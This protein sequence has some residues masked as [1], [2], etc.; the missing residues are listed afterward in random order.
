[1]KTTM[2]ITLLM[3]TIASS[4]MAQGPSDPL[5]SKQ[6]ALENNGQVV[7]KY[8]SDLERTSIKGSSGVDI[9]WVDT[10]DLPSSQKDLV[11]AVID[12]GVDITHPDLQGRIWFNEAQCANATNQATL[13][14]NGYNYLETSTIVKDDIGHGTHVAGII[15]AN[16]N[17]NI[18]VSGAAD[19][20]VKIMP[21]KVLNSEVNG[22]VYKNKVITDV[23][24]DA[25]TFAVKNGAQVVNLSLGWPKLIDLAKVKKAFEY[26]EEN[27][28]TIIA[29]AGNNNKDLPVF[30]CAYE[31]VICVGALGNNGELTSFTNHGS[32]VDIVA[33]GDA[34]VSTLPLA[35]ESRG[36]RI[37]GY[38]TKNGSSQAAPYVTA[39][40]A[41]LKLLHPGLT[42]DQ[43]RS[44]LFRSSKKLSSERSQRFVKFGALDMKELLRLADEKTEKAFVNPQI[45]SLTEVK[46]NSTDR[47][48]SFNLDL[49]NMSG[50]P[51]KGLVCLK[52][53]SE[54]IELDQNCLKVES[55]LAHKTQTIP[56]TGAVL[57]MGSDSH[58][59]IQIQIDENVYQT[60]LVLSRDLNADSEVISHSLG[61]ASFEDMGAINGDKRISRM[62]RVF[63][64]HKRIGFPEY[65]YLERLKQTELETKI[66]LLTKDD[67]KFLIKNITLPKVE[68]VIS[69]HRQD[70]NQDGKMDYFVYT[71]SKKKD[72]LQFYI[73]DEKLNPLFKNYPLWTMTLSTFEGLPVDAVQEKF[74]W[75][76][77]KHPLLGNVLVP[78]IYRAYTMPEVDNSKTIADRV[79]GAMS[80]QYYLNPVVTG[81]KMMLELRVIDSVKMMKVL[82]KEFGVTTTADTKSVI[83]LKPFPQTAEESQKGKIRSL[84]VVVEDGVSKLYQVSLSVNGN[85][86]SD[87]TQ[88]DSEKGIEQSLIYPI[89]DTKTGGITK[90]SVF[91]TLLNRASAEFLVKN[92]HEISSIVKLQESWENPIMALIATFQEDVGKTYL[93][94]SRSTLTLVRDS[95]EKMA[96][97][98]YRDSSFPG[99]SFSESLM[100]ILSQGRPGIFINS[101]L[102]YGERLYSMVDTQDK[103]FI[104]PL[105]LSIGV[106]QGCVPLNPET[107]GDNSQYNYLFLCTDPNKDVSLKILPMSHN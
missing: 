57:D 19:P 67:G 27:N 101:T 22:F 33:P 73:F 31:N 7:L 47:K 91:T 17:N 74:E 21:L 70:I 63:D 5:Y 60:S 87:I 77:L 96:L 94:E 36:L 97:P 105:R 6:W 66:S 2:L 32:K 12:S 85:N 102:I 64:K 61:K 69:I 43:V 76:S 23:I 30:P 13:P 84:L 65:F 75:L 45:K 49:K 86:F 25:L 46:F 42:N 82:G 41:N 95:E 28:V 8:I 54:A 83:L 29:A 26:A 93:V 9:N 39:A 37:K 106:P 56:V 1:M 50:I 4:A 78:S 104:R 24:A 20:R 92:D 38:E 10:K 14:C 15:A 55:I 16:R 18:G 80:H 62:A 34:I 98:V 11:V 58:I 71:L 59:L 89:I 100:P 103:G 40:I 81:Q 35:L 99:Q 72:E 68:K 90:E 44:L 53:F 52:T 48:F 3:N 51:Y 79:L 107:L 88:L